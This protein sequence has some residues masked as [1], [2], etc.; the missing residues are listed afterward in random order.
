MGIHPSSFRN[1]LSYL[2]TRRTSTS[3]LLR[4]NTLHTI[5]R[6]VAFC[7]VPNIPDP[8]KSQHNCLLPT[9]YLTPTAAPSYQALMC[10]TARGVIPVGEVS[11]HDLTDFEK[12]MYPLLVTR[13]C[14]NAHA[15]IHPHTHT[16]SRTHV[17]TPHNTTHA[18]QPDE[19][20]VARYPARVYDDCCACDCCNCDVVCLQPQHRPLYTVK[21]RTK[22]YCRTDNILACFECT[23]SAVSRPT[24]ASAV[25]RD[26]H[27]FQAFR[28]A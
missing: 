19:K 11:G 21:S 14:T 18:S 5:E 6:R 7:Q 26:K 22:S 4:S 20:V 25:T 15:R 9:K 10:S 12:T 8:K 2:K 28:S 23:H 24:D 13:S 27:V 17:H 16:R 1:P 3:T